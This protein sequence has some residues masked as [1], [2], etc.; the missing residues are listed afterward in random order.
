MLVAQNNRSSA[1]TPCPSRK[2]ARGG[3]W[4]TQKISK[5]GSYYSKSIRNLFINDIA[6]SPSIGDSLYH[7]KLTDGLCSAREAAHDSPPEETENGAEAIVHDDQEA[8]G[9]CAKG[10][11]GNDEVVPGDTVALVLGARRVEAGTRH[12]ARDR[13]SHDR[14]TDVEQVGGAI[15]EAVGDKGVVDEVGFE[16]LE[17]RWGRCRI[18]TT[19]GRGGT[20]RGG[21]E[22]FLWLA[23]FLLQLL[24]VDDVSVTKS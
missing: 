1:L 5:R 9:S 3:F 6:V 22:R 11:V 17:A 15:K 19:S 18:V 10:D 16:V 21:L 8:N 20:G 14:E 24:L 2:A 13:L 7:P 4:Y 23:V 12:G